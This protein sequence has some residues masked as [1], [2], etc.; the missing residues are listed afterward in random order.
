MIGSKKLSVIRRN[1]GSGGWEK[2]VNSFLVDFNT[3]IYI[4]GSNS[5][6]LEQ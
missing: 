2:A 4:T 3:D 5:H 6:L 1:P